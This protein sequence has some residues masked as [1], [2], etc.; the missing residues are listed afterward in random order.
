MFKQVMWWHNNT[1]EPGIK[2]NNI[3]DSKGSAHSGSL[4]EYSLI[5]NCFAEE[6]I[7]D[8]FSWVISA[9]TVCN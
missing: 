6:E 8:F 4:V 5:N 2:K 3:Y 1:R 7:Y 9:Q